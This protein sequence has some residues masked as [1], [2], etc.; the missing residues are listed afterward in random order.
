MH[1]PYGNELKAI[2]N[3]TIR[4][5][6]SIVEVFIRDSGTTIR[7]SVKY[8][9]SLMQDPSALPYTAGNRVTDWWCARNQGIPCP[10]GAIHFYNVTIPWTSEYQW[11][12]IHTIIKFV[13]RTDA[14]V[15]E[16]D[17]FLIVSTV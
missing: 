11:Q 8:L 17:A 13:P 12:L 9:R 16:S 14:N 2:Q 5:E 7:S 10:Y 3:R 1:L 4:L 15:K 6:N